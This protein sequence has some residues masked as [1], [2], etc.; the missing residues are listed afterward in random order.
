M[1]P[2]SRMESALLSQSIH[3]TYIKH[4]PR[5]PDAFWCKMQFPF[6]AGRCPLLWEQG[7]AILRGTFHTFTFCQLLAALIEFQWAE[8]LKRQLNSSRV[9][10]P[11][12]WTALPMEVTNH[13]MSLESR[14]RVLVC[15]YFYLYL[16]FSVCCVYGYKPCGWWVHAH[17]HICGPVWACVALAPSTLPE[18]KKRLFFIF[19]S[20][21][22]LP[23]S[24]LWSSPWQSCLPVPLNSPGSYNA[25]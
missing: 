22:N 9:L 3:G 4:R 11:P 6:S 17:I 15:G 25:Q 7:E 5:P 24:L 19:L 18:K 10:G 1:S 14:P 12:L 21:L 23:R 20:L 2:H 16:C 13:W 8:N